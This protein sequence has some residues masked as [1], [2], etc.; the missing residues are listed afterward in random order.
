MLASD[1]VLVATVNGVFGVRGE[2]RLF[3]HDRQSRTLSK[4]SRVTF[5]SPEGERRNVEIAI[6]SGA[7][8]RVIAKIEGIENPED[9]HAYIGWSVIVKRSALPPTAPNEYYI[10]DLLELP[11]FERHPGGK[12]ED[13]V[14]IGK[15]EDVVSGD[16]DIWVILGES[17]EERYL[18]ASPESVLEVDLSGGRLVVAAGAAEAAE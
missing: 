8:K 5:M 9:A 13:D 16:R 2:V 14:Q 4:P 12:P 10:H 3:L 15:L 6:R 17:G 7:G 1:E 11:V 18:M